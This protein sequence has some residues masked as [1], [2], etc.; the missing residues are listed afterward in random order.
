MG[1]TPQGPVG[2]AEQ[3]TTPIGEFFDTATPTRVLPTRTITPTAT[4]GPSPTPRPPILYYV[5]AGDTLPSLAIH[6][7]VEVSDITS[8]DLLSD[9][10]YLRPNQLL[11]I[12]DRLDIEATDPK[13]ILIPDSEVVN[14]PSAVNFDINA[15]VNEAGGYM[16][17]YREYMSTGWNSG[18]DVVKRVAIENS[19]NPRLLLAIVE[20]QSHWIYGQPANLAET[21]YP[22]GLV[23][24]NRKDLYKQLSWAVEQLSIGYYGWESGLVTVLEFNN[25]VSVR[26]WPKANAGTAA[27]AYLFSK[28]YNSHEWANTLNSKDMGFTAL[29]QKMYGNPWLRAQTVEPL[30]PP[31][32]TQPDLQLPYA[33]GESWSFSGGP[34][35]AWGPHG[36]L[37]AV[38]FAPP[39]VASGCIQSDAWVTASASGLVVRTG[40]GLVVLDL[41]GDGR[42]ETGW[43]LL[44]LHV[45]AR[46]RVKVGT[47][48]NQDDQ[49]GHPSCE[50]GQATGTHVHIA[51]KYNGQWML[52]D[53]PIP[54]VLSGWRVHAGN[55]EYIGS[56]TRGDA[57]VVACTCGS[58]ESRVIRY[59]E[60]K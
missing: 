41:D 14:S 18:A 58:Y 39:S 31:D 32:F 12:P 42:E 19:I 60:N 56:M 54:M 6:F 21:D 9:Q 22:A 29:Y 8:P 17:K 50:G 13:E 26:L 33:V 38:D 52:A 48:I 35:P 28:L 43:V 23:D 55:A 36:A 5:Q 16:S 25:G 34:H 47:W 51:R 7:G 59:K 3:L 4:A 30:F 37:A 53:G 24:I 20:Y 40:T 10:G 45:A 44:Y 11:L 49:L 15:F 27:V 1:L 46:E 57:E 2:S